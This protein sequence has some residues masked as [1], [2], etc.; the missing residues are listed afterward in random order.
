MTT[1]GLE[2]CADGAA[3]MIE[4]SSSSFARAWFNVVLLPKLSIDSLKE[5][6]VE[7]STSKLPTKL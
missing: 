1:S 7:L 2:D 6:N 3:D 4:V 5:E